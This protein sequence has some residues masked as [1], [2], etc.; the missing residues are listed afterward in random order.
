LTR[1]LEEFVPL[2][3]NHVGFYSCGPTVYN[4]PHIGNM[5]AYI[6]ADMM[7]RMFL[8]NG[9]DVRHVMNLTDVGHLTD[10]ADSGD[11]KMERG[12]ARENKSV[13]E[14]SK[15]YA[16]AFFADTDSLNI[17]RPNVVSKATDYIAEQIDLVKKLEDLGYTYKIDGDGIYYDTSKFAAY[18]RLAGGTKSGDRAGARVEFND[19]KRNPADFALWKFSPKNERRQMEWD[20]PWGVGFPGW[21]IECSAMGIAELGP[22]FDIHTGGIDHIPIHHTNEIAQAEPVVGSPW[23]NYWV[24]F[25]FLLDRSGKMSKSNGEFLTLPVLTGRGYDPMHYRY[26]I[27]LGHFQSQIAF[28]WEAMDAAKNG[29][30][31]IVRRVADL[32]QYKSENVN[33][34]SADEWRTKLLALMSDNMKTAEVLAAFQ[35][36]LKD[37]ALGGA[38]KLDVVGFADD[39][40]G[41]RFIENAEKVAGAAANADVPPEVER[42]AAARAAAKKDRDFAAADSLRA[43]IDSLGWSVIDGK[44]GSV[45]VKKA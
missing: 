11:D 33:R 20:S 17:I 16:A 27:A 25:E 39:L 5:R 40:L 7:K 41:L 9:Y 32:L 24:H 19:A 14:I 35:D 13:W 43:E 34:K 2:A 10:D 44:D 31:R 28:S 21:H 45:I 8:A 12:A 1:K 22:H 18:G 23:V 4:F 37:Q 26:L 3:P 38:E 15:M 29:Y 30:E 6:H 42:L 36:M